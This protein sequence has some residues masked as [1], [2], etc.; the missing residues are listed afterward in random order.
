M[1]ITVGNDINALQLFTSF[2]INFPPSGHSSTYALLTS[3]LSAAK[4]P[5]P[6]VGPIPTWIRRASRQSAHSPR[7]L[8]SP[9][10]QLLRGPKPVRGQ[11]LALPLSEANQAQEA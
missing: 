6:L 2:P 5:Q 4:A 3:L 10:D 7:T 8:V 9:P 11:A 1:L